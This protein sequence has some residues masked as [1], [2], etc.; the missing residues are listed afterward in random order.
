[1]LTDAFIGCSDSG[2]GRV[3]ARIVVFLEAP[4]GL[5]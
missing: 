3:F 2:L 1:M 4:G 5:R